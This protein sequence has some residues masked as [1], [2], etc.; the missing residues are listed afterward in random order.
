MMPFEPDDFVPGGGPDGLEWVARKEVAFSI[1]R[2]DETEPDETFDVKPEGSPALSSRIRLRQADGGG[3]SQSGCG[4]AVTIVDNSGPAADRIAITP[5]PPEANADHG[6]Y[7]RK[8][9]FLALPD[10][11]ARPRRHTDLHPH[12]RHR[13]LRTLRGRRTSQRAL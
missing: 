9:A 12:P 11:G 5:V 2:D 1:L 8:D 6:P 7:Y 4:A 13:G 10:G 3:C